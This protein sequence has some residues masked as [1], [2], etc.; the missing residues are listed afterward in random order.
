MNR[1]FVLKDVAYAAKI[2]GG[3]IAGANELNVLAPGA[4]ALLN[5]KGVLLTQTAGVLDAGKLGDSKTITIASGRA[6]GVQVISEIPRKEISNVNVKNYTAPVAMV[7]TVGGTTADKALQFTDNEEA[8]IKIFDTSFS[9]RYNIQ[10][11]NVSITKR[12]SETAEAAVDRLVAKINEK[13][14]TFVTAAKVGAGTANMGITLT[15]KDAR[16]T[17]SASLSGTFLYGN[18]ETTTEQVYGDGVGADVLQLEKDFSVEEGNGNYIE[19]GS[20]HYSRAFEADASANYDLINMTWEGRHSS[21]TRSH[22]VMINRAVI[23]T[24]DG[25]TNQEVQSIM[26]YLAGVV[27]K[28]SDATDGTEPAADDGTDTDGVAGN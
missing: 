9:S 23:A 11:M 2:G 8:V 27:G 10:D 17:I 20:E 25:A 18:I 13:E 7:I 26:L 5:D 1:L 19:Y 12:T 14:G 4:L 22:N 15:P 24:V 3:T 21:P 6:N 28:A 16:T